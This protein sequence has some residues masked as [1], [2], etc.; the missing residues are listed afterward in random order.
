MLLQEA[1]VRLVPM[2]Y[3][4]KKRDRAAFAAGAA[5]DSS[6]TS[7]RTDPSL[8]EPSA[9]SGCSCALGVTTFAG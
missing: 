6:L 8:K 3:S 1:E 9:S 5:D 2:P 4:T 7:A